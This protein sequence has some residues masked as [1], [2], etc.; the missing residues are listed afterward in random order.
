MAN[1][2]AI[3]PIST[4]NVS[5][6]KQGE[7]QKLIKY[8]NNE[9]LKDVPDTFSS[10]A[11]SA[12]GTTAVFEGLPL[13]KFLKNIKGSGNAAKDGIA[14]LAKVNKEALNTLFK[15]EGSFVSRLGDYV[16]KSNASKEAYKSVKSVA[17]LEAKSAKLL[18]K[19]EKVIGKN[20]NKAQKLSNKA[21][22][23]AADAA[24]KSGAIKDI[25]KTVAEST[26]KGAGKAGKLGKF[27]KSSGAGVMLVFSGIGEC[28]TEV[29]PTFKELGNEKG[30]KQLGK[31]TIK[32]VGDTVGFIGGEAAG[33]A[34]G[35][36]IG[37]A[38]CPVVGTAIGGAMGAVV[39]F[40]G[41]MLGSF[42]AGKVT[43]AITGPSER[44]IANKKAQ[45]SQAEKLSKDNQSLD[46]LKNE[47]MLKIQEDAADGELSEDSLIVL[48]ALESLEK[49]N[50][51]GQAQAV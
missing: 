39:G 10:T 7:V 28:F 38:I 19:A 30:M 33:T 34:V 41:G 16:I 49:S 50:P 21:A 31:S 46:E 2:N 22:N 45:E 25:G 13:L 27:L 35:A 3:S 29:V 51:F 17:K 18:G 14:Q 47:V 9:A 6:T 43:K 1:T 37:T 12:V 26:A 5:Y 40:V 15:G 11:K 23:I 24:T 42:L 8:V 44:E 4:Q 20:A 48:D 36:A 32:V